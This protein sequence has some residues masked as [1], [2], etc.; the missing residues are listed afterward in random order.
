MAR[1][2]WRNMGIKV[3]EQ[4]G[5]SLLTTED[6][7]E[8]GKH[9]PWEIVN[10][11]D[12]RD[13]LSKP[14]SKSEPPEVLKKLALETLSNLPANC[15]RIW[16]DG[17]ASG[18]THN[19]GSG[20]FIQQPNKENISIK[21]PAGS[22][23]SSY[24]AELIAI[25]E[26]LMWI[27]SNNLSSQTIIILTDSKSVLQKIQSGPDRAS[28]KSEWKIWS[29]AK[30]FANQNLQIILQWVPGHV[31]LWGNEQ[32]DSIA[33]E[34]C[35]LNQSEAA[36]DF[37]TAS[38]VIKRH[39]Y[40][41]WRSKFK[42]PPPQLPGLSKRDTIVLSQIRAGEHCPLF[43]E[44]LHRIGVRADKRCRHCSSDDESWQH[45]LIE[46]RKLNR[47]RRKIFGAVPPTKEVTWSHPKKVVQF[48]RES[49]VY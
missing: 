40:N 9:P 49:G 41:G 34:A 1:E 47:I 37:P 24:K 38:A 48:L 28:T 25:T 36:I 45:L 26:A 16:T 46:C 4:A 21:V 23:A 43:R 6:L 32:V 39:I 17:S 11:F 15:I 29:I 5:L 14:C 10:C 18:G 30:S 19:A 12:V 27:Q 35:L 13:T 2:S 31:N 22:V 20:V 3:S 42:Q 44:Y 7:C 33:K 8:P